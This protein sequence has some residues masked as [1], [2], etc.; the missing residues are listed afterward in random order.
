MAKSLFRRGQEF[1][2]YPALAVFDGWELVVIRCAA[3]AIIVIEHRWTPA[4][5][6]SRFRFRSE[7]P[8]NRK[9]IFGPLRHID[10]ETLQRH[11]L[12]LQ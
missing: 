6:L 9:R 10:Y 7:G 12:T 3:I 5:C 1:G 11:E 2:I 4:P 8:S